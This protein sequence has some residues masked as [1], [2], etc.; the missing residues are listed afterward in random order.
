MFNSR[1]GVGVLKHP[2]YN[3]GGGIGETLLAKIATNAVIGGGIS[4][5]TGGDFLEGALMGGI[6]G[7][8]GEAFKGMDLFGKL[9][10]VPVDAPAKGLTAAGAQSYIPTSPFGTK[11]LITATSPAFSSAG[12]GT[13][14]TASMA[15]LANSGISPNVIQ[16]AQNQAIVNAGGTPGQVSA[17]PSVGNPAAGNQQAINQAATEVAGKTPLTFEEQ[18]KKYDIRPKLAADTNAVP[19]TVDKGMYVGSDRMLYDTK[20]LAAAQNP[21]FFDKYKTELMLGGLGLGYKLLTAPPNTAYSPPG[22]SGPIMKY[23]LGSNYQSVPNPSPVYPRFAQGGIAQLAEG[24]NMEVSH[25]NVNFMGRD[26]YPMSQQ[27]RSFYATPSQMPTSAQQTMANYEPKA[28]PLTGQ[29]TINMASGGPVSFATGGKTPSGQVYY[30]ADKGQYYT[31]SGGGGGMYG[32]SPGMGYMYGMGQPKRN[33]IGTAL[34][35]PD[36]SLSEDFKASSITPVV[37]NPSYVDVPGTTTTQMP[38]QASAQTSAPTYSLGDSAALLAAT[39]PNIAE[40]T[41]IRPMARGGI[42]DLGS[43]SDGG[44]MLRGPGD[45]MSD[46]IPGVIANKR[47]ARLAD[48]EFVVPADVVSHLGNGST[49]AGAK[50][51]Y[52]MMNKVR[53]ARTGNKKQGKQINPRKLMPA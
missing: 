9:G 31:Q 23:K 53:Q 45:G 4:A 50:Q 10:K 28:N 46:S 26:M 49:D 22:P 37:Y 52:A 41:N 19:G 14:G 1:F 48:G 47:P 30:D 34:R 43:Y 25:P 42:A 27:D 12:S 32:M 13:F 5:L 38:T 33:Y 2:G 39:S 20:E 24:G 35:N 40:A 15:N 29:P 8:I 6:S 16:A 11:E 21:S 3:I 17:G 44:R 18:F 51:L 7:G 36:S